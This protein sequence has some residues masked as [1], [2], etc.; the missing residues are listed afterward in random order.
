MLKGWFYKV[1]WDI[2]T[3]SQNILAS[4]KRHKIRRAIG[5]WRVGSSEYN[6]RSLIPF[7]LRIGTPSAQEPLSRRGAGATF[8]TLGH[9][10]VRFFSIYGPLGATSKNDDFSTSPKTSQITESIDPWAPKGRSRLPAAIVPPPGLGK[11]VCKRK[12]AMFVWI[13][14]PK[15]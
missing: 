3:P 4:P 12:F 8:S 11:T 13:S 7:F 5:P 6:P 15:K 10:K 1:K 14:A 9:S 2:S